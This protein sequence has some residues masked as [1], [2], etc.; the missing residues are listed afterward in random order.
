MLHDFFTNNGILHKFSCVE[1]PQQ[2]SIVERKHQHILNVARDL[3]FQSHV[4]LCYWGECI[5]SVV[6]LINR[7]PSPNLHNTCPYSILF[8]KEP[9][10]HDFRSFGCLTYASTLASSRN[11]FSPRV[12][13]AVFLSYPIGYKGYKLLDLSTKKI[14][15]SRD[16]QFHEDIYPFQDQSHST[17]DNNDFPDIP[18]PMATG[19]D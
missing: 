3:Y 7:T 17:D 1:H 12:V 4:P 19:P 14:F 16:T 9:N 10:Y 6:F 13:A 11:K 2:N 8:N 18:L 15:I 5:L